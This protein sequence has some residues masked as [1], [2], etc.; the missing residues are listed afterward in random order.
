MGLLL[1]LV[2]VCFGT[3]EVVLSSWRMQPGKLVSV[4]AAATSVASFNASSWLPVQVPC[5]VMG[6]LVQN[7]F[8]QDVYRGLALDQ[9]DS[10]Q[11]DDVWLF[12]ASFQA[13][14]GP[15]LL[16]FKG[17]SYRGAVYINGQN[18]TSGELEGTFVYHDVP[19]IALQ[20][21]NAVTVAITR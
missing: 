17:I 15:A 20:G 7:G 16:T 9:V 1:L 4:S 2:L 11:F 21:E 18:A 19:F 13:N 5:T 14:R 12:R 8:Y 3:C 10:E 6:G